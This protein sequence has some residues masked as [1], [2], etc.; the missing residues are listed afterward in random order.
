MDIKDT[1][2]PFLWIDDLKEQD[3]GGKAN[4][5]QNL[6]NWGLEV[7]KA[8]VILDAQTLAESNAGELLKFYQALG[9]ADTTAEPVVA[10][11]SSATGEDGEQASFAGQYETVLN[12]QGI[13]ALTAAIQAC[14][15]S[16]H[17]QHASAYLSANDSQI[18][19]GD[20][21]G[22]L[23]PKMNIVVQLMVDA[24]S[25]GVLFSAD[26]VTG[27][28][29]RL[30]IDAIQGLGESLVNGEQT[31][32]HYEFALDSELTH[33]ELTHQELIGEQPILSQSQQHALISGAREASKQAG[34]PLDMEWAFD[35][36]GRLFWLQARPVTTL[37]TDLNELDTPIKPGDVLTRCN[38]GE[39]MPNACCPLTFST[40][41]RAIE[42][43]MQHMHMSYASR[44]AISAEW[45]QVAMSHGFLFLNLT[46]AAAAAS[47]VLGVDVKSLGL[48][49]C[50]R[51][52][53][54]LHEP[55]KRSIWI[56][57]RGMIKLL[58]YLK[59]ADKV[60]ADFNQE[61]NGFSLPM[62]GSS[63]EIIKALDQ[64]QVFLYQAYCVHLQSSTTSGFASNVLQ[65]MISGGQES[66]H[67]EEAEAARLMAGATGVES[68]ILVEQLDAISDLIAQSLHQQTAHNS[69]P[70]QLDLPN[71][72]PAPEPQL[73][74]INTDP[75][76]ALAWLNTEA[77][78]PIRDNFKRF[79][80][81]HGH[82]SYRELCMRETCWADAPEGLI[83][84]MQASVKARLHVL[85]QNTPS[86]L[87]QS[88][89][90]QASS[91]QA[92]S[93]QATSQRPTAVDPD[94]LSRGLRWILPKAHNAV[95]RREASKSLLVDITNR[96]KRSYRAL[97]QQLVKE[98]KLDD[99]DQVFFFQHDELVDFV[100]QHMHQ[101][102]S[103]AYWRSHTAQRRVALEFQNRLEFEEICIDHPEPSDPRC[104][105][106][107]Q[108]SASQSDAIIG[109]PVSRGHENTQGI[110]EAQARL[111]FNV[112]EA[113]SLQA[114]EIL[115][116][117][118][119]DVG[120]TPY[121][122]L[123]AGLVT[124]V[125]SA[126][127]HGAVIAREYGL[128]AIVNTRIATKR[129]Q[130][131]DTLRLNTNTGEVSIVARAF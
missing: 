113:S 96:F 44:P 22:R 78:A 35:E 71:K 83:A 29:D 118:I 123:I 31:P 9:D 52:V 121:F 19:T 129:I 30:V 38:I 85:E 95:R 67:Q 49:I 122:S 98:G 17:S 68:A 107:R 81:R 42:H 86:S 2:T 16:L 11:R 108:D 20:S 59:Q 54:G 131:G 62:T 25:A 8:F 82:R 88:T 26:P 45:T 50:G 57:L 64:A 87:Q 100:Q 12:V 15:N 91:Q 89:L 92:S 94:T 63:A 117:P 24:A 73:P 80:E 126:V 58:S 34:H 116:A 77:D 48:S 114:G 69:K 125:G 97:G 60:I 120:W 128:P 66:N 90:Q 46:G 101:P 110:I 3:G 61:A 115:V 130:T 109:R 23:V 32:D 47:T 18:D 127:S 74:F 102:D 105:T 56:R 70:A 51:I 39:M 37:G 111:A 27:R 119:T 75:E 28:H 76:H 10:V 103:L 13:S 21:Q 40:T 99:A 33:Q 112:S 124:D 79:I 6:L 55:P 43:G 84:T 7:P 41:G 72:A 93:Q 14:I 36:K 65:A 53:E 4:G 5:L 106:H 104:R 1:P